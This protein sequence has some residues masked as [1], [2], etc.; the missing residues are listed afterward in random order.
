MGDKI[1]RVIGCIIAFFISLVCVYRIKPDLF[2]S[3]GMA[4]TYEDLSLAHGEGY[5]QE[6]N[7]FTNL[8]EDAFFIFDLGEKTQTYEAL[9]LFF[10]P[11][12]E[13]VFIDLYHSQD[14]NETTRVLT[15][16][17][18]S[19]GQT[20]IQFEDDFHS[21]R[22]LRFY[23]HAPVGQPYTVYSI[24][25][26]R[27]MLRLHILAVP[28][29]FLCTLILNAIFMKIRLMEILCS[30]LNYKKRFFCILMILGYILFWIDIFMSK[31]SRLSYYFSHD[32]GDTFMDFFNPIAK[33][34]ELT[35]REPY[36]SN[37]P[38]L[39]NMLFAMI[40]RIIPDLYL[41]DGFTIR[42]CM[43]AEIIFIFFIVAA[44]LLLYQVMCNVMGDGRGSKAVVWILL[45]SGPFLFLYERGNSLLL[46]VGLTLFFVRYYD[47]ENVILQQCALICFALAAAIKIY[48]VLFGALL[49]KKGNLRKV[50]TAAAYTAAACIVP[51][52]YY[53]GLVSIVQFLNN[54]ADRNGQPKSFGLGYNFSFDTVQ[55]LI[56]QIKTSEYLLHTNKLL[57]VI[58]ILLCV[59]T[60]FLADQ[61]WKKLLAVCMVIV[62]IPSESYTYVLCFLSVPCLYFL[63]EKP[64]DSR[65]DAAYLLC[66][67]G[68]FSLYS[69]NRISRLNTDVNYP[70]SIGMV[71]IQCF[72][73]MLMLASFSEECYR[74]FKRGFR[75]FRKGVRRKE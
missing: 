23:I 20:R 1:Q 35:Y 48:P 5:I 15:S 18:L 74:Y 68:I 58:P 49:L 17:E 65:W 11:L 46:A 72:L 63:K 69:L 54:L 30:G 47:D 59:L 8:K 62:W 52:F 55:R 45:L 31:G 38:A 66:F 3:R 70:I 33:I 36:Y 51:F 12:E 41:E 24:A 42:S 56:Y 16:G 37:Y 6:G 29:V 67:V 61:K 4:S 26:E 75:W 19:A 10:E 57:Y 22:F 60:Y 44:V 28:L 40:R 14:G 71:L 2:V 53:E 43:S 73:W 34:P 25:I 64:G 50:L 27:Q 13:N 7:C 39:A 32:S 9:D 21:D